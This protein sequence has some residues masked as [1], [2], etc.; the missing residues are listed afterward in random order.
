MVVDVTRWIEGN[1]KV[2][3]SNRVDLLDMRS[4]SV[5][6][7]MDFINGVLDCGLPRPSGPSEITV[8]VSSGKERVPF[9]EKRES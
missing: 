1:C 8:T 4:R 6:W 9:I 5:I 2:F 3:L 7:S